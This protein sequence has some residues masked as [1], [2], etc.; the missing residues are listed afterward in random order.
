MDPEIRNF[1]LKNS[2]RRNERERKRED[3]AAT[4]KKRFNERMAPFQFFS[5]LKMSKAQMKDTHTHVKLNVCRKKVIWQKYTSFRSNEGESLIF[6]LGGFLREYSIYAP[7]L[8]NKAT[9]ALTRL[10]FRHL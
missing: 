7:K 8:F 6:P 2:R 5:Y 1:F 10:I 9:R 4:W 3:L